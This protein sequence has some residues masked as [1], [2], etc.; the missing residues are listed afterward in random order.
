MA[1]LVLRQQLRGVSTQKLPGNALLTLV[2]MPGAGRAPIT[3]IHAGTI[4]RFRLFLTSIP[5]SK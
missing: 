5:D 4:P 2:N 1:H 3:G